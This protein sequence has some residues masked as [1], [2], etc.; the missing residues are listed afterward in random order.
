MLLENTKSSLIAN[1]AV[2]H[3]VDLPPSVSK[4][5][6]ILDH[7]E[8]GR[9]V[10]QELWDLVQHM[11]ADRSQGG[12]R[13]QGAR[14]PSLLIGI[15]YDGEGRL[16][17]PSHT[18]KVAANQDR[19]IQRRRYR[20]YHTRP[21]AEGGMAWRVTASDIE[22]LVV[23]RLATFLEDQHAV[24][25]MADDCDAAAINA[26]LSAALGLAAILRSA[27]VGECQA[28]VKTIVRRIDLA[29]DNI[30]I[31]INDAGLRAQLGLP[32]PQGEVDDDQEVVL[33]CPVAKV[34][35]GHALRLILPP[36]APIAPPP[37]R[38][39]KLVQLVAEAHAAQMLVMENLDK[40]LATIAAEHSRCRSRLAKLVGLSCLAPDIVTA[41]IEGRQ[42]TTLTAKQLSSIA[43][44]LCWKEQRASL[45]F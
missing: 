18:S 20:Y 23:A 10:S 1:K 38:D 5:Y 24:I 6:V 21:D 12:S 36:S 22:P 13:S 15:L 28:I 41:I 26:L 25:A 39:D 44:P 33:D 45:G 16:M 42:P 32:E 4:I 14:W 8:G 37:H 29:H 3:T 40:P 35:R 34:R 9:S 27:A 17:T 31:N 2:V 43:L 7:P 30:A 11:L 19:K